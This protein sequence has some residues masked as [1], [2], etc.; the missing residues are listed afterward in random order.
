MPTIDVGD[1]G[2]RLRIASPSCCATQPATATIGSWPVFVSASCAQ[3][4]EPRVELVLGA[5]A[6]A[7]GVDDD[8]VGVR[9]VVGRF[10]ARP[11]RAARHALGVVHVHL[12]AERLDQVFAR[13]VSATF[14]FRSFAF[15][16][17]AR[18]AFRRRSLSHFR[19]V[20]L[21]ASARRLT[22]RRPSSI[23]R[24]DARRPSVIASPPSMRASSS[25]RPPSSS[26]RHVVRVRPPSTR[27]SIAKC[28]SAYAA[29]CGRC[30][31][32]ST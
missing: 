14:A 4:A 1:A 7:A 13:H 25:T 28:V 3:F 17:R 12:A 20:R 29:I 32:H 26:R 22:R 27:F 31:M 6:H 15:A 16:V 30:V 19:V 24:A 5:L 18:F 23:S 2:R 8:D 10:V 11:A 21:A 9:G